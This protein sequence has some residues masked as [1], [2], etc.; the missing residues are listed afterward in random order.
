[1][2]TSSMRKSISKNLFLILLYVFFTAPASIAGN[3]LHFGVEQ[4]LPQSSARCLVQD[5]NGNLWIG[6][7]SGVSKYN[8]LGFT[9][10]SKKDGLAE[11]RV[12]ACFL[13]HNGN[14]WFGHWGGGISKYNAAT[15]S[16]E[17]IA[18]QNLV[19]QKTITSILEDKTGILWIGTEGLGLIKLDPQNIGSTKIIGQKEGLLAKNIFALELDRN[20]SLWLGTEI[21]IVRFSPLENRFEKM[22]NNILS[23]HSVLAI[24]ELSSGKMAV[25]TSD[26]GIVVFSFSP[27]KNQEQSVKRFPLPEGAPSSAVT[28]I[29]EDKEHS[30]WIGTAGSGALKISNDDMLSTS[31][32]VILTYDET[33]GLSS[34]R[35]FSI[36]Q[37]REQNIW[38]GTFLGLNQLAREDLVLYGRAEGLVN[39]QVLALAAKGTNSFLLGTESG[40]IKFFGGKG[41]SRPEF[42]KVN[43]ITGRVNAI[44][45]Q[46]NGEDWISVYGKGVCSINSSGKTHWFNTSNGLS[47]NFI[48]SITGD[49]E[50]NIWLGTFRE[51]VVK[52]NSSTKK[53]V[54]FGFAEG[55]RINTVQYVFSDSKGRTWFGTPGGFMT[56][57]DK[58]F[59]NTFAEQEGLQN[60]FILCIA[61]DKKHRI[62]CGTYGGG[63]YMFDEQNAKFISARSDTSETIHSIVFDK[64]DVLWAGT[65]TGLSKIFT[66]LIDTRQEISSGGFSGIEINPN[67]LI[68]DESGNL[69]C[70]SLSGLVKYSP[71]KTKKNTFE[72]ITAITNLQLFFKDHP[73]SGTLEFAYDMNYFTFRFAGVSLTDPQRTKYRYMLSGLDKEWSPPVRENYISYP[74]LRPGKYTFKVIAC[75]NDGLWNQTPATLNFTVDAPFWQKW[76]FMLMTGI[77]FISGIGYGFRWRIRQIEKKEREKTALNKRIANIELKALQAQM[78]PHFIFNTMNSIQHFVVSNDA[79]SAQ[80]Y[81]S[82]F[83]ELIRAI[84]NNSKMEYILLEEEIKNLSLYAELESLRFENGFDFEIIKDAALENES[85]EIPSMLIQPYVENAILHGLMHKKGKG[86]I[87]LQLEKQANTLKCIIEDNGVGRQKAAEIKSQNKPKHK[88]MGLTITEERLE[89]LNMMSE[90]KMTVKTTDL[91]NAGGTPQGTRVE[92]FIPLMGE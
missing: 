70:G 71:G 83:A 36:L 34:N 33:R 7:M 81:L 12:T 61:E 73:V 67:A 3:F 44:Y 16:I 27:E 21:G 65:S 43:E 28:S 88:S 30:L 14:I 19:V 62:W 66:S 72:P 45:S 49:K 48:N 52:I 6:T 69:W 56:V 68:V 35:V 84:L 32:R 17:T 29:C 8:G 2:N 10:Y 40:L 91:I 4:G 53:T 39:E 64:Q 9:T 76:W 51:G 46:E 5:K 42:E 31:A 60:N 24:R 85:V 47:T 50:G 90:T 11:D 87:T 13:D 78:N 18:L 25:G 26:S 58:G 23:P 82:K 1:M 41:N 38:I 89:I 92:I 80:K 77:V 79:D 63:L 37:D 86:K 74:N 59:F 75:N 20:G 54:N 57:Y 22:F 55:F 15:G